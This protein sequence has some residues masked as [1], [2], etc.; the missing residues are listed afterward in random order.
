VHEIE[1]G[2]Y[3]QEDGHELVIPLL[4]DFLRRT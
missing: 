2:H 3:I 4:L 1:A